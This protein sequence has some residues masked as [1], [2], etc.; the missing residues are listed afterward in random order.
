[1]HSENRVVWAEGMFLRVQHFQ[2][3]DRWTERLV[4]A[5]TRDLRPYPWGLASVAIN[6]DL[7]G[8][9]KFA[10]TSAR[11]VFPDGTPFEAPGDSDLPPALELVEGT[12]NAIL[13]LTLPERRSGAT[14]IGRDGHEDTATRWRRTEY[15]ALDTNSGSFANAPIEVGRQRLGYALSS[16]R[17]RASIAWPSPGSS[18]SARIARSCL[19]IT[20]SDPRS[21]A[22]P[23]RRCLH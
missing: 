3:S 20:S 8:V 16:G 15:E 12:R 14:E 18:K 13:Y 6:R 9:G 10:L 19:T 11:G 1:M 5:A 2:Q 4:R 22:R 7:L 17:W 21:T 23:R